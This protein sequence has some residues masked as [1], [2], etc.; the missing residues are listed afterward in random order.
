[1]ANN[2]HQ[3]EATTTAAP[4]ARGLPFVSAADVPDLG[5]LPSAAEW[6]LQTKPSPTVAFYMTCLKLKSQ[7]HEVFDLGVGEMHPDFLVPQIL[8]DGIC[9]AVQANEAHYHSS[10]G[11]AQLLQALSDDFKLFGVN[12]E[13][14]H[15]AVFPGPK[16][17]LFKACMAILLGRPDGNGVVI[18]GPIYES[19][20]NVPLLLTGRY[21]IVLE[22][23]ERFYPR[24]ADLEAAL[25]SDPTIRIVILN[26]PNNPTG[27]VY[28]EK[29]LQELADVIRKYPHVTVIAD[30]VYRFHR[31]T[32]SDDSLVYSTIAR[33]LPGQTLVVGGMSKEVA[34]TGLRIGYIASFNLPLIKSLESINGNSISC[35]NLPTQRGYAKFLRSDKD[36]SQRKAI[37]DKLALSRARMLELIGSLEGF[38]K[39]KWH[40]PEGA[41]Y[42]FPDFS[43]Y[44]GYKIPADSP[45][46]NESGI[47]ETDEDLC[48]YL[49]LTDK[50]AAIPGSKFSGPGHLRIA[51]SRRI[52][53]I[54]KGITAMS[55][56]LLRLMEQDQVD[57]HAALST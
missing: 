26:Y 33:Y 22:H 21:P 44:L 56:G 29:L 30:E 48:M 25:A 27:A 2:T 54:E 19:F 32:D 52:E 14:E 8:K 57:K 46:K 12:Y 10:R 9:E 55:Q 50:V 11:D 41:F 38:K 3:E 28:P 17:A 20:D 34:G 4:F 51:F 18:W 36:L 47:I 53:T 5:S 39:A 6:V 42:F 23:D 15:I 13:P 43:E 7:G 24:P 31:Y 45:Y 37:R 35:S 40:P 49:L 16:D 1:M